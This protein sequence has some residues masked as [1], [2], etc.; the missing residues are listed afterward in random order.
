MY[1]YI[2]SRGRRHEARTLTLLLASIGASV[3]TD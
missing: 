3:A 1:T 2:D